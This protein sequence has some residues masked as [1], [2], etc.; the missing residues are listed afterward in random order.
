MIFKNILFRRRENQEQATFKMDTQRVDIQ[1][2]GKKQKQ[3]SILPS[4]CKAF[5]PTFL[6]GALLKLFQDVLT[7]VNPQILK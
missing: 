7:F 5:G 3:A 4:L 1:H 2:G 6:F